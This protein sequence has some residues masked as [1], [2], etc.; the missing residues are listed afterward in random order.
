MNAQE[1]SRDRW[2]AL[3]VA[4]ELSRAVYA[5]LSCIL[6]GRSEANCIGYES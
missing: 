6:S 4:L 2:V 1:Y 5:V 3:S